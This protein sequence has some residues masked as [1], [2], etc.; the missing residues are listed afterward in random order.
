MDGVTQQRSP[1]RPTIRRDAEG[2]ERTAPDWESLTERL[3]REAQESGQFDDLPQRGQVLSR[4]DAGFAGDMAAANSVLRNA[5]AAPPWIEI[6]KEVRAYRTHIKRLL[7]QALRTP[8]HGTA[9]LSRELELTADAHDEAVRRLEPLAP[10][11]RQY[12]GPIDRSAWR[13]RLATPAAET[14][15]TP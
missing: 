15:E 10:T 3:I 2:H 1:A 14:T 6:D 5:G 8:A 13:A 12:R 11:A 7:D 4:D 9:R